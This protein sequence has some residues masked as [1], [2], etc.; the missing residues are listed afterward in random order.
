MPRELTSDV[1]N[2]GTPQNTQISTTYNTT[3]QAFCLVALNT[4][5]KGSHDWV[6]V[7][8]QGGLQAN[9]VTACPTTF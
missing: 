1:T 5:G 6:Y 4:S 3:A 2:A 7:S 8:S 9:T